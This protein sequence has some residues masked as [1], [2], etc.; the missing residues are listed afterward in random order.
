MVATA[1]ER[2]CPHCAAPNPVELNAKCVKCRKRMGPFCFNC[3][4]PIA[5]DDARACGSCGRARW[6]FGDHTDLPCAVEA[7]HPG[8]KHRWMATVTRN[9]AVVHEWRCLRCLTDETRT[10]AFEHFPAPSTATL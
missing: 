3:Y 4:A 6:V 10:D 2:L 5:S 8:R 9:G 7:G 1:Q